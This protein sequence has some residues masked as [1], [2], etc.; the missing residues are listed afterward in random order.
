MFKL[1]FPNTLSDNLAKQDPQYAKDYQTLL[2]SKLLNQTQLNSLKATP[3]KMAFLSD[4]ANGKKSISDLG[5][6]TGG[7]KDKNELSQMA[8]ILNPK[9]MRLDNLENSIETE[10]YKPNTVGSTVNQANVVLDHLNSMMGDMEALKN[11]DVTAWNKFANN[12]S[13]E[14]GDNS[15]TNQQT[16]ASLI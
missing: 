8:S 7:F 11:G 2:D 13:S 3:T 9:F 5:S 1:L 10:M 6:G 15:M 14:V 12:M 4:V 16:L